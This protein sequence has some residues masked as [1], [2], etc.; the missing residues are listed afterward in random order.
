MSR[1]DFRSPRLFVDPP[2]S[3]GA[4]VPL[5]QAQHILEVVGL[6]RGERNRGAGREGRLDKKSRA[7]EIVAGHVDQARKTLV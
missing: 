3:A 7:A 1:Y 5:A 6:R 4:A 2:L